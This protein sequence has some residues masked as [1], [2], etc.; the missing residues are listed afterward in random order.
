MEWEC[1]V[2]IQIHAIRY[3]CFC[4]SR[5]PVFF[6]FLSLVAVLLGICW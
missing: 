4:L 1:L 3:V 2:D 5:R 6:I